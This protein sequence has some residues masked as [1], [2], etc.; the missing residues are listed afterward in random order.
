MPPC[1]PLFGVWAWRSNSNYP[2]SIMKLKKFLMKFNKKITLKYFVQERRWVPI[3]R[4]YRKGT[5]T[6]IKSTLRYQKKFYTRDMSHMWACFWKW[7]I[8]KI[9]PPKCQN[10]TFGNSL[11]LKKRSP[12]VDFHPNTIFKSHQFV[13]II[14]IH[15]YIHSSRQTIGP[16]DTI[17][18]TYY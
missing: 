9:G 14:L 18:V 2:I 7:K 11:K 8:Q 5:P 15:L 13:V 4:I 3:N 12:K 17:Y 16:R 1:I 6:H 10:R